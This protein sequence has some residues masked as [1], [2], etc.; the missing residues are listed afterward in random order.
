MRACFLGQNVCALGYGVAMIQTLP[1]EEKPA[2]KPLVEIF[3]TAEALPHDP[4]PNRMFAELNRQ[5][6]YS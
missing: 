2:E 3:P 1:G 4:P 6:H 5:L